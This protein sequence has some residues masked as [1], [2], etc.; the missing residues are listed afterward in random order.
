VL[1]NP[2]F[3]VQFQLYKLEWLVSRAQFKG[4]RMSS[5]LAYLMSAYHHLAEAGV[6][7][8]LVP[9]G[10]LFRAG[11][12]LSVRKALVDEGAVDAVIALPARLS[13]P[14]TV[15][16]TAIMVLRRRTSGKPV[17]GTLLIDARQLGVRHGQKIV[18]DEAATG[19]ILDVYRHRTVEPGFSTVVETSDIIA[20]DFNLAPSR[21]IEQLPTATVD[22]SE[23]R[24]HIATL[25]RHSR[26]LL[27]EYEALI[28][29]LMV[30]ARHRQ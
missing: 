24:D 22:V 25:D 1:T 18:L 8:I 4:G 16:E 7:A 11:M 21:Y 27:D 2:P 17:V 23:R 20:Q 3:G 6:A 12:D 14:V 13:A 15:I 29:T 19:K 5:E 30:D 26:Q 9:L 28:E 10:V